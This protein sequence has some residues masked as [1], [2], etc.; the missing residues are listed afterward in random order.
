MREPSSQNR[1]INNQAKQNHSRFDRRISR[2]NRLIGMFGEP[3]LPEV[4]G[5]MASGRLVFQ[6]Q[7][8]VDDIWFEITQLGQIG[9]ALAQSTYT[10]LADDRIG[11]L[12]L[13][14]H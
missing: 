12:A 6:I 1:M 2:M 14:C 8:G 3:G 9:S 13:E 7:D 4:R 5:C 10:G 11:E